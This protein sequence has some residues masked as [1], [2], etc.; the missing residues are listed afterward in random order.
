MVSWINW[1]PIKH[2]LH[3]AERQSIK[4]EFKMINLI[5][6]TLKSVFARARWQMMSD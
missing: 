1:E 4:T 3:A 2:E 6:L 5:A